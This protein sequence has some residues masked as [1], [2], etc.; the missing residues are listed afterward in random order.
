MVK[1]Y[2]ELP[3]GSNLILNIFKEGSLI[4]LPFLFNNQVLDYS[5]SAIEDTN[6]CAIDRK[7]F[8]NLVHQNSNFAAEVIN[9]LNQCTLYNY[10]RIVSLTHK[11]LNGKFAETLIFLSENIYGS[12][13]FK[14]TLSRKDLAEYT[15][16]SVMSIIRAIK[17]FKSDGIIDVLGNQ[18]EILKPEA[19]ERIRK[20]G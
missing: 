9:L 2:K 3:D 8:E 16:V 13:R 11:Q 20:N 14:L 7:T 18:I 5:V 10:N 17:D 1:V 15:G 19:L 12:T 4:G 6:I